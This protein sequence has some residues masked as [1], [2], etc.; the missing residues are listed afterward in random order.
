MTKATTK[1]PAKIPKVPSG[2]ELLQ[3]L[4]ILKSNVAYT[5]QQ[6]R[7]QKMELWRT[8]YLYFE[9]SATKGFTHAEIANHLANEIEGTSAQYWRNQRA[10]GEFCK[11]ANIDAEVALP[12][13]VSQVNQHGR[14]KG[15]HLQR[16]TALLNE[17]VGPSE[18]NRELTRL[19]Y[20]K[21]RPIPEYRRRDIRRHKKQWSDWEP[22]LTTMLSNIAATTDKKG[23]RIA[24]SIFVDDKE[25]FGVAN[26]DPE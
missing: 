24:L 14:I 10:R 11:V 22:E 5:T 13:A 17:G 7:K 1:I 20:K 18:I 19:G 15:A 16:L 25:V 26:Y 6:L 23:V 9:T 2:A 4:R 12:S 21:L 8:A 3:R